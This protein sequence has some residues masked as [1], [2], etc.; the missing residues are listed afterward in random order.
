MVEE[1]PN[2]AVYKELLG[3]IYIAT[4]KDEQAEKIL[5]KAVEQAEGNPDLQVKI[6]RSLMTIG[7][8]AM[9]V[10]P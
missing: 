3:R 4:G 7:D 9:R 5:K 10:L 6:S 2:S 8:E 1:N